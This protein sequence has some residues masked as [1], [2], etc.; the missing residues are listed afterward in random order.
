MIMSGLYVKTRRAA[1]RRYTPRHLAPGHYTGCATVP[2]S[3]RDPWSDT[4]PQ[5]FTAWTHTR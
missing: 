4:D 5:L 2:T 1:P 3:P